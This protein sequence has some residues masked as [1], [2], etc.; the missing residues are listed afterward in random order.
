MAARAS[1]D[2]VIGDGSDRVH[3][4]ERCGFVGVYAR[5]R[6]SARA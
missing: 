5:Q 6:S 1:N 2:A 3:V 4:V